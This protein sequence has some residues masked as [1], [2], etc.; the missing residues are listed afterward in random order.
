MLPWDEKRFA[1]SAHIIGCKYHGNNTRNIIEINDIN[2]E[3]YW[4]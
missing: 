4:T 1:S 2:D 3:K